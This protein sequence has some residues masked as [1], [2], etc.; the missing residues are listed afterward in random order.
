M[1]YIRNGEILRRERNV[2]GFVSPRLGIRFD[3]SGAELIVYRPDNRP[4]LTYDVLHADR[5]RVEQEFARAKQQ[6]ARM[7]E[8]SRK[9]RNGH[10]TTDELRELQ[11]LEDEAAP[12]T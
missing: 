1:I 4:F 5:D 11:Q 10:A 2:S 12:P 9:A 8:L 7:G 6:N 3:L